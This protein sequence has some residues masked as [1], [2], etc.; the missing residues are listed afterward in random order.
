MRTRDF[1]SF[2]KQQAIDF[3]CEH[4]AV[5]YEK[6]HSYEAALDQVRNDQTFANWIKENCEDWEG[7]MEDYGIGITASDVRLMN[8]PILKGGVPYLKGTWCNIVNRE[9]YKIFE[10]LVDDVAHWVCECEPKGTMSQNDE[11]DAD[12]RRLKADNLRSNV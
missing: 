5:V 4:L 9:L 2:Y 10:W 12:F 1:K 8:S 11:D 7:A 6:C 3:L